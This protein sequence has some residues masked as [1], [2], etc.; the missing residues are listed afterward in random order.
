MLQKLK[1]INLEAGMYKQAEKE[2]ISFGKWLENHYAKECGEESIY[3]GKSELEQQLIKMKLTEAGKEAPLT[4]FEAQLKVRGIKAFGLNTDP[5]S[6]FYNTGD[7]EVLF[8]AFISNQI[9]AGLLLGSLVQE[10][11]AKTEIIEGVNYQKL[12]LTDSEPDRQLREVGEGVEFPATKI[13]VGDEMVKMKK[14]GRYLEASYEALSGQKVGVFA[15][16]LQ[17]IGVQIGI[18]ETDDAILVAVNG[19]GNSNAAGKTVDVASSGTIAVADVINF[20]SGAPSPY[21]VNKFVA[22]KALLQEYWATLAGMSNPYDQFGF[23]G[24]S[25]P[26]SLEWDRAASLVDADVAVGVDSRFAL[27]RLSSGGVMTEAENIIRRQIKGTAISI[28]SGFMVLDND[29][30]TLFDVTP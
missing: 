27:A 20:A 3:Y 15:L 28:Y 16:F 11:V 21:K 25:L 5:I 12:T 23:V 4:A 14:Y 10:L 29:A 19:D 6:K 24:I 13:S 7:S 8:P 18:D 1:R 17:R 2:G 26:R 9:I 22:K 30:V